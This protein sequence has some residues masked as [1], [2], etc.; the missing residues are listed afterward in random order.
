MSE[1]FFIAFLHDSC[2]CSEYCRQ[3]DCTT[4]LPALMRPQLLA[5]V[6]IWPL[7]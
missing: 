1:I 3:A 5:R 4:N 2:S 6:M 7:P